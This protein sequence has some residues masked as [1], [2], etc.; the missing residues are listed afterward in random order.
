MDKTGLDTNMTKKHAS[1]ITKFE[2]GQI[3]TF[4]VESIDNSNNVFLSKTYTIL[5]PKQ[6][7]TV[8]QVIVKNLEGIFGWVR[9]V[10]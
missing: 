8:F 9:N 3:Y 5:T 4:K 6:K 1:V 7:E 2:P 10:R